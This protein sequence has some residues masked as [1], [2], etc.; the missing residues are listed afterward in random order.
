MMIGTLYIKIR[1]HGITSLKAKRRIS[2][3][4]KQKL[5]NKFNLAVA[6]IGSENSLD[7]LEIAMVTLANDKL[8]VE[9]ILNKALQMVEAVSADDLQEVKIEVF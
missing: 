6:E 9:E 2:S 7:H 5:K 1:L 8:R 3:S 4:L